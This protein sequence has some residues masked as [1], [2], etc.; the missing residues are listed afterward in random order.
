MDTPAGI[1]ITINIVGSDPAFHEGNAEIRLEVAENLIKHLNIEKVA[2]EL[3]K[4]AQ[5]DYADK[6]K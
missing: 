5:Q 4:K 6:N 2:A 1:T 3:W